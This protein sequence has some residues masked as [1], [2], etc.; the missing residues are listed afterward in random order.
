MKIGQPFKIT[1]KEILNAKVGTPYYIAPEVLRREYNYKCDIWS[2]GVI[3]YILL[4]GKPPF[5]GRSSESVFNKILSGK[6][7][8]T[9]NYNKISSSAKQLIHKMLNYNYRERLSCKEC[10]ESHWIL[11]HASSITNSIYISNSLLS[12]ECQ[13]ET[14]NI[15]GKHK[16]TNNTVCLTSIEE[17]TSNNQFDLLHKNIDIKR[18]PLSTSKIINDEGNKFKEAL[19][20]LK[21]FSNKNKFQQATIAYLVRHVAN[22]EI[23]EDLREIF[24]TFDTDNNGTLSYEEIKAGFK[25]Y[26]PS[27][28]ELEL[29]YDDIIKQL[30]QDQNNNI[31]YE[32]FLRN[33]VD[34]KILLTK[35]NLQ[36]AFNM[37]D[38]DK[39]G[40]LSLKEI[41][42]ALGVISD[43][44]DFS[45]NNKKKKN[46]QNNILN[47]ILCSMDSDGNGTI[48]FDEFYDIMMNFIE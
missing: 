35:Q 28:D 14:P 45:F 22:K 37:F 48:S 40:V 3:L 30:D 12:Q 33:M 43:S 11:S 38:T 31:E 26:I 16:F 2:L 10:L 21:K 6:Y 39:D 18:S 36:I 1:E 24:K 25:K 44:K 13:N 47:K 34:M 15:K 7:D 19:D 17:K 41:K 4:V 46:Q 5:D 20:N 27:N 8:K 29:D 23:F 42:D 32:E 9:G